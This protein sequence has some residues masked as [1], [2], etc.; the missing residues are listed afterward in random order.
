MKIVIIL[1]IGDETDFNI[2]INCLRFSTEISLYK[3]YNFQQ[4]VL[5]H[6]KPFYLI[7]F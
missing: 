3:L 7:T 6:I 5:C 2:Y 1:F 4:Y